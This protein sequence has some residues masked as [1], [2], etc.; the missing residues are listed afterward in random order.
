MHTFPGFDHL[1]SSQIIKK[2]ESFRLHSFLYGETMGSAGRPTGIRGTR[3]GKKKSSLRG[4]GRGQGEH[5]PPLL[6][7]GA[8]PNSK[9]EYGL[10]AIYE[11]LLRRIYFLFV[12]LLI[13]I[14]II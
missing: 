14:C 11:L 7:V 3:T 4:R 13:N 12:C 5:S 6:C 9:Y 2:L 8:K 1:L 10:I